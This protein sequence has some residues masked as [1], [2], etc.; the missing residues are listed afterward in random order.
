M[1]SSTILIV[2]DTTIEAKN[3]IEA[4]ETARR[5]KPDLILLDMNM[6]EMDGLATC[7]ELRAGS[8]VPILMLTVRD[9]EKDKVRAL[10]AGADDYVV[11]PFGIEELLARIRAALR[12]TSSEAADVAVVS[13]GLN[14][15][16]AA[17]T[18]TLRGGKPVHLTPKEFDL[19]HVLVQN[20]GKPISHRRLLQAV[21]G[22]DSGEQTEYLRVVVNQLRKKI[23]KDPSKPDLIRTEPWIGYRFVLP[24][25]AKIRTSNP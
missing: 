2:D 7:R 15:D 12:R 16:F 14:I 23:E 13:K 24:H 18:V 20:Q 1:K 6:P 19:L 11:K 9:A 22:P 25:D 17:R 8:E 3:G 10:D 4:I 5:E 21:W